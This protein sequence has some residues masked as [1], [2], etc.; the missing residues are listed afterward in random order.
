M[1]RFTESI[2]C[3][4]YQL[5][6]FGDDGSCFQCPVERA[7]ID[8][9]DAVIFQALS[10]ACYL[11]AALFRKL[12]IFRTSEAVFGGEGRRSV[13]DELEAGGHVDYPCVIFPL[14]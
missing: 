9:V 8:G 6:R 12:N 2:S 1:A 10:Q 4:G 7:A 13:A 14:V 3:N 11:G 5:M